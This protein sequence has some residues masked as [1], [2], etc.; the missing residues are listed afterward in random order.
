MNCYITSLVTEISCG[1]RKGKKEVAYYLKLPVSNINLSTYVSGI[2][3]Y[4][5][6]D[7]HMITWCFFLILI[8]P[9]RTLLV[10]LKSR[11]TQ[12][13]PF[14]VSKGFVLTKRWNP[15]FVLMSNLTG[16]NGP[17]VLVRQ[18]TSP[19]SSS[20]NDRLIQSYMQ[21]YAFSHSHSSEKYWDLWQP[22]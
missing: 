21:L 12:T 22:S 1:E 11:V 8:P 3:C 14:D 18:S 15:V 6:L 5:R 20:H 13:G 19:I 9:T 10:L 16:F 17:S 2:T 4:E 7:S